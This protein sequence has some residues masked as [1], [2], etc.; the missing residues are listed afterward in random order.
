MKGRKNR[1]LAC[2]LSF[3]LTLTM[4]AGTVFANGNDVQAL[5]VPPNTP[6]TVDPALEAELASLIAALPAPEAVDPTDEIALKEINSQLQAIYTFAEENSLSLTEEQHDVIDA[7]SAAMYP[8][9]VLMDGPV[10]TEDELLAAFEQGGTI[11]L[12]ADFT[13]RNT[14][15][16]KADT[17]LDLNGHTLTYEFVRGESSYS[18]AIYNDYNGTPYNLT[19]QDTSQSGDGQLLSNQ[20]LFFGTFNKL[21]I[22]GGAMSGVYTS[23]INC[24]GLEITGGSIDAGRFTVNGNAALS[25]GTIG[26]SIQINANAVAGQADSGKLTVSGS[27]VSNGAADLSAAN[28]VTLAG[29]AAF[30]N[31]LTVRSAVVIEDGVS[32]IVPDD[33]GYTRKINFYGTGNVTINGGYFEVG[34]RHFLYCVG[35]SGTAK[36]FVINGGTFYL[37]S[38]SNW[39]TGLFYYCTPIINGGVFKA[40]CD[41]IIFG[42]SWNARDLQIKGGYFQKPL[43]TSYEG[44]NHVPTFQY[45]SGYTIST[46]TLGNLTGDTGEY[47]DCYWVTRSTEVTY[48][49][50]H[51]PVDGETSD[52]T[53][54]AYTTYTG[55][56]MMAA[57]STDTYTAYNP[58]VP[59]RTGEYSFKGWATTSGAVSGSTVVSGLSANPTLYAAWGDDAPV[60]AIEYDLNGGDGIVPP[61]VSNMAYGAEVAAPGGDG[62]SRANYIFAGW[63]TDSTASAAGITGKFKVSDVVDSAQASVDAG[64]NYTY[65]ITLFAVWTPKTAITFENQTVAYTGDPVA[66]DVTKNSADVTDGF[67]VTYFDSRYENPIENVPEGGFTDAGNYY[68]LVER[69]EDDIYA[70]VSQRIRLR[71]EPIGRL[72]VSVFNYF[73]LYDGNPHSVDITVYMDGRQVD[74]SQVTVKYAKSDGYTANPEY[75]LD[76]LPTWTDVTSNQRVY[77]QVSA[78]GYET[79]DDWN[80]VTIRKADTTRIVMENS[81]VPYDGKAHS[82]STSVES[83]NV[84]SA[85]TRPGTYYTAINGAAPALTYYTDSGYQ[86]AIEGEPTNAGT[87]YVKAV[88]D[89]TDNYARTEATATLT[90]E[91]AANPL[92]FDRTEGVKHINDHAFTLTLTGMT[93]GVYFTSSDTDVATVNAATGEVTITGAG[94]TM[95][96]AAVPEST[97]YREATATYTLTVTPHEYTE[98]I[99]THPTC[100]QQGYTTHTCRICE[101]SYADSYVEALGHRYGN[102]I[103]V[104]SPTCDDKGSIQRICERCKHVESQD[105]DPLGHDWEDGF[106]VDK[107]ATCTEDGSKSIHCKNCDAVLDSTVIP[108]T[109]HFFADEWKSDA[110]NHWNECASCGEKRNEAP[111]TFEWVTDKE[112]T[113]TEAGSRHEVCTVCR[114]AKAAVEIPAAGT[115]ET[116]STSGEDKTDGTTAPQTG[117]SSNI[118]LWISILLAAGAV[119]TGILIYRRKRR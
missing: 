18:Y 103:Q 99:V 113:P 93:D 52:F 65:T 64:G 55:G 77:V 60:Y 110:N 34:N 101:D 63:S 43:G 111:H 105:V 26:E 14:A 36:Q 5:D 44:D 83:V 6:E 114:Y 20:Y 41:R 4:L 109:G 78:P 3:V 79:D 61:G 84:I 112:A 97:N 50:D 29:N 81:I 49:V 91:Q 16:L 72:S 22:T 74:L 33:G 27:F 15:V 67:T 82:L 23:G 7:V 12:G 38:T 58:L 51:E 31:G 19:I 25:G 9:T 62:L 87:Y 21:T 46:D 89:G 75:T 73:E 88:L 96:T 13:F 42:N 94:Q 48:D 1:W 35:N 104:K 108:A 17:I 68:V 92:A 8:A 24:S 98:G 69:P 85:G 54:T 102:W 30:N 86:N 106:T 117:D 39:T 10:T 56:S 70:A 100:T 90:I 47:R 53:G 28:G 59:Y 76:E 119:L 95:I 11:T 40:D 71:I 2:L 37:K 116:P 45:P 107:V 66:F 32:V 57:P 115:T 118:A 80:S